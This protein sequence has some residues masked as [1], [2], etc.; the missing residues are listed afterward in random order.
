MLDAA[1][2][3][4]DVELSEPLVAQL[5]HRAEQYTDTLIVVQQPEE[6]ET[7]VQRVRFDGNTGRTKRERS[8]LLTW[9]IRSRGMPQFT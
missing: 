5:G 2:V 9:L 3:Y 1:A 4:I 6:T 7:I 8:P